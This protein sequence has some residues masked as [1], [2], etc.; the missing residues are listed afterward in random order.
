MTSAQLSDELLTTC[1]ALL[2]L[3]EAPLGE[4]KDEIA[5]EFAKLTVYTI[6]E[7][8]NFIIENCYD[9]DKDVWEAKQNHW[10]EVLS[11]LK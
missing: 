2:S 6:I 10:K 9:Y 4:S 11:N 5:K 8:Y 7:E 1:R 3:P